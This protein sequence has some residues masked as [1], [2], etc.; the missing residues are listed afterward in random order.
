M[1]KLTI[2][3]IITVN[4]NEVDTTNMEIKTIIIIKMGITSR[5]KT[6]KISTSILKIRIIIKTDK[7]YK[8]KNKLKI[9][10]I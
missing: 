8:I 4:N 10:L 7:I 6:K 3:R 1:A 2:S 9:K 5:D